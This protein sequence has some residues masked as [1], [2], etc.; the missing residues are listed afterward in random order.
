MDKLVLMGHVLLELVL[1]RQP[2][3]QILVWGNLVQMDVMEV[4][5]ELKIAQ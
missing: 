5:L 3:Q 1:L 4:L 2:A